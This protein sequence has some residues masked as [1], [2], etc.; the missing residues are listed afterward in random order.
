MYA[1]FNK[2]KPIFEV[3]KQDIYKSFSRQLDQVSIYEY[4]TF[5]FK[6]EK[7]FFFWTNLNIL[8]TS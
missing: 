8:D 7:S 4:Y 3:N 5:I 1:V 2:G 6:F